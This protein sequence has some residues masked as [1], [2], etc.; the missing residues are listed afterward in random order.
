MVDVSIPK[1]PP[2]KVGA[3]VEDLIEQG[4][5]LYAT[6]VTGHPSGRVRRPTLFALAALGVL[7]TLAADGVIGLVAGGVALIAI[8]LLAMS[9]AVVELS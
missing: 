5:E 7:I 6:A 8:M 9:D 4:H 2:G 3:I 1:P